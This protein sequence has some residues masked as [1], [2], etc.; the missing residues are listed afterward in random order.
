MDWLVGVEEKATDKYH[1]FT[2]DVRLP[3]PCICMKA[4]SSHAV[5]TNTPV[6]CERYPLCGERNHTTDNNDAMACFL[7]KCC[8]IGLIRIRVVHPDAR[9]VSF[10]WGSV[11]SLS[12]GLLGIGNWKLHAVFR[13]CC[14]V[15]FRSLHQK[16]DQ[17]DSVS[18]RRYGVL[19][20]KY[21]K[22]WL[23]QGVY[24]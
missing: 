17:K 16:T 12:H 21:K 11:R 4:V 23:A 1:G 14:N 15:A 7:R 8:H 19:F 3:L 9:A 5:G 10:R 2:K 22:N 18:L 20:W 6:F 24:P 13:Y